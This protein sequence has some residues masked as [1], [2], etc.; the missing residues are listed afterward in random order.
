LCYN[1]F[2]DEGKQHKGEIMEVLIGLGIGSVIA[3]IIGILTARY[4]AKMIDK[5][6]RK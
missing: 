3:V 5:I 2:N 1:A 6:W 4:N